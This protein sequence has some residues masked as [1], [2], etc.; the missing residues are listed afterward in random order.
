M[1]STNAFF[2]ALSGMNAN[3]KNIDVIGN[4][5]ANVNTTAYKSSRMLFST[6]L[7][8]TMH[9][10]TAPSE[11]SGGTNPFQIGNGVNI[12]GTQRNFSVGSTTA[13][14]DSRDLAIDGDGFFLVRKGDD[15]MYTRAGAFRP[16]AQ[17]NLTTISGQMLRGY[18]VDDNFN[19][20]PGQLTDLNIPVGSLKIAQATGNVRLSGN[21]NPTGELPTQGS[22]IN[23]L[24][25]ATAGLR[26][27][28]GAGVQGPDRVLTTT[29][30][31]DIEDPQLVGSDSPLFAEGQRLQMRGAEKGGKTLGVTEYAVTAASTL[32]DLAQWFAATL[33]LQPA[34]GPNPDG[35]TPGVAVDT[36]TGALV[37]SG[38]SG[39][40]N[41]LEIEATDLRLLSADGALVRHPFFAQ[42]Q[43]AADGESVRTSA[44]VYD[45]L[46]SEVS[47][48][49][50]MVLEERG[51]TGTRWRYYVDSADDTDLS[52]AIA[53]GII[54]FDT[55]GQPIPAPPQQVTIDRA[56]TGA[57][58]PL[59]M[60]FDFTSA[61]AGL[62]ALSSDRSQLSV[63]YRD[64]SPLGTLAGFGIARDGTIIGTFNN[65]LVRT[66]GQVA[67][68]RFTNPEGLQD[69]GGNMFRPGANSGPPI[70]TTPGDFGTGEITSGALEGSNVDLGEEFVKMILSST[71]YS[72]SSRVI[73]T[74]DELLQQLLVLGR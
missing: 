65:G 4:N 55:D 61:E 32:A 70:I 11:T 6:A 59:T 18:A 54:A 9:S 52:T 21:L 1:A 43:A 58:T 50:S 33:G 45:S 14:G 49:I 72:A 3:A 36:L 17:G 39:R 47:V 34:A 38:N 12:A 8:R 37:I 66:L 74:A 13:T 30:L 56:G 19:I 64:G 68:A 15:E 24:G 63:T 29:R 7:S 31:I 73:R 20:I 2:T 53:S 23:L 41:D 71:G 16:D 25:S 26:A 48:D 62:T 51:D 35:A 28:S 57:G 22:L 44:I 10:G 69:V 67:L 42:K 60:T 40:I 46:G 27:V 5:V